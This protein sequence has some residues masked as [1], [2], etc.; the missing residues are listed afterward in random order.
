MK[1]EMSA[2][3]IVRKAREKARSVELRSVRPARSSS[4]SRS[5]NTT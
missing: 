2:A 4:L 3:R 1:L 5:K